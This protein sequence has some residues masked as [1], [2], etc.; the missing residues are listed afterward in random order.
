MHGI[1]EKQMTQVGVKPTAEGG[2]LNKQ[3]ECLSHLFHL[4]A[5]VIAAHCYC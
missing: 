3:I 2:W 1:R 5:C 4:L